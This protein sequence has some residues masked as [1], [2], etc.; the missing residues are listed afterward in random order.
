MVLLRNSRLYTK[1][2]ASVRVNGHCVDYA[3]SHATAA[4]H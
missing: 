4:L 3:V 1:A 2:Y